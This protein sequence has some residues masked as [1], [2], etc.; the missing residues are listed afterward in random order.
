MET[1]ETDR[2]VVMFIKGPGIT[3]KASRS[4]MGGD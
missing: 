2:L 4:F 3:G 1:N